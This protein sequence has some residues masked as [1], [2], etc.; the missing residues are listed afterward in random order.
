MRDLDILGGIAGDAVR[1]AGR[2]AMRHYRSGMQGWHKEPG[3]IVTEA[4]IEIDRYLNEALLDEKNDEAWLSEETSDDFRRLERRRVWIVDPIDGTRSFAE[5]KP[6][7]TICVSLLED[8]EPVLGIVFNPAHEEWFEARKGKGATRNGER[9]N[10][11]R[12]GSISDAS[13]VVSKSEN[14]R[15]HFDQ[16]FPNANVRSIG[17]LAYKLVLVASGSFDAYVSWRRSHDWDI[18]AADLILREAGGDIGDADG[19][20]LQYNKESVVH[21]GIV[22]SGT[23]LFPEIVAVSRNHRR[24]VSM[25][26]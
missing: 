21:Q 20:R 13:I 19:N 1:E 14:R 17:S 9:L 16:L 3:Q 15:R 4:D 8:C 12:H 10:V 18:A 22:A 25:L 2:I 7:F 11:S 26:S 23:A 24:D 5:G 6:E